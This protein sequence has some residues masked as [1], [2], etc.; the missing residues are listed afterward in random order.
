MTDFPAPL[1]APDCAKM[2]PVS[3]RPGAFSPLFRM[4][5]TSLGFD[6]VSDLS[7]RNSTMVASFIFSDFNFKGYLFYRFL[8]CP[9]SVLKST[10]GG[11]FSCN[12]SS[13]LKTKNFFARAPEK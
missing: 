5:T 8:Q 1:T 13:F 6:D 11:R 12:V 3:M 4:H 9:C 10:C 7:L 2:G